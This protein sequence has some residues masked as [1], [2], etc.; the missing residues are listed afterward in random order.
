MLFSWPLGNL[1]LLNNRS[2]PMQISSTFRNFQTP[3][4][5]FAQQPQTESFSPAG[6]QDLV[7][8]SNSAE[9]QDRMGSGMFDDLDNMIFGGIGALGGT[10]AGTVAGAAFG[11]SGWGTAAAG[12]G[13]LVAGAFI[14][15]QFAD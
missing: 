15:N 1:Q 8:L 4:A 6:Q 13:G 7:S 9:G 12:L 14:G 2:R 10:V 3:K 11:L 5:N